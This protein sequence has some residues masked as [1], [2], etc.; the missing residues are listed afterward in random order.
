MNVKS[1]ES[2]F[3]VT[4]FWLSFYHV[5]FLNLQIIIK[6]LDANDN[7]PKFQ[8]EASVSVGEDTSPGTVVF[9]AVARDPDAGQNGRVMYE[10]ISGNEQGMCDF[11]SL[12]LTATR[13]CFY[14]Y[15]QIHYLRV[16]LT[17]YFPVLKL[18]QLNFFFSVLVCVCVC[19]FVNTPTIWHISHLASLI[20]LLPH[21][22]K[23]L[24]QKE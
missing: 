11:Q 12:S 19:V 5:F 14:P 22:R 13:S 23:T 3:L 6:V 10:I 20:N 8:S 15:H 2:F 21:G 7:T 16:A 24:H 4:S 1:W 17:G 18:L 9:T